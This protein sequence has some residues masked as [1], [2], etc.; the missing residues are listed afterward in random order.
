MKRKILLA[1]AVAFTFNYAFSQ[2]EKGKF[3]VSG[4][5]EVSYSSVKTTIKYDGETMMES[6]ENHNT[7]NIKPAIGYFVA[8]NIALTASLDYSSEKLGSDKKN[9]LI[10]SPGLRYYIGSSNIRPLLLAEIGLGSMTETIDSE[11]E[12]MGL[13]GYGLAGGEAIFISPAISFEALLGYTSLTATYKE[14]TKLKA[15]GSGVAFQAG[16]SVY[17]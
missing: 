13:F 9:S 1:A 11:E 16:F 2:T 17:F 12:K 5:T 6:D 14:D 4:S 15:I 10:F 7:F 3:L 8:N